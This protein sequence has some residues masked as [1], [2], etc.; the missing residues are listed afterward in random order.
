MIL[1]AC[2]PAGG[3]SSGRLSVDEDPASRLEAAERERAQEPPVQEGP[4]IEPTLAALS[5]S[6]FVPTC[7][8]GDCHAG[9]E[10]SAGLDLSLDVDALEARLAEPSSQSPTG[11]PLV[12]KGE[13]GASYLYLKVYLA[14]PLIG[15]QMPRGGELAECEIEALAAYIE[16]TP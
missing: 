10:P 9:A 6:L 5:E 14:S 15:R 16:Q 4:C 1:L 12:T 7:A 2:G 8:T 3:P 11:M 13:L